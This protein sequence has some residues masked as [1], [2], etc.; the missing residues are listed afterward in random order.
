[1]SGPCSG[2]SR[3]ISLVV[4]ELIRRAL[5]SDALILSPSKLGLHLDIFDI[6]SSSFVERVSVFGLLMLSFNPTH[7]AIF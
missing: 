2:F 6:M 7:F 4:G 3:G 5:I 1:M